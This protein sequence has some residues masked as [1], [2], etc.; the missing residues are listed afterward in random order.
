MFKKI[1]DFFY[2]NEKPAYKDGEQ[3]V[4]AA[5]KTVYDPEIPLDIYELGLIYKVEIDAKN[6]VLIQM[7][8]TTPGCPVAETFPQTVTDAVK[9][10][11]E[12]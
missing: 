1:K 2:S 6:T 5:L 9:E 10:K 11:T 8:L 3:Q 12:Y 4:I 7:T